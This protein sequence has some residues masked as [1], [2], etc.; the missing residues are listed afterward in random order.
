MR[1][2]R[3][4][5]ENRREKGWNEGKELE[6]NEGESGKG[7]KGGERDEKNDQGAN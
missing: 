3:G 2:R 5:G 6:K 7:R 4:K 1:D